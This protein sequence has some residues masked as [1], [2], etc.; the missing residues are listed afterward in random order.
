MS[1]LQGLAAIGAAC[2]AA[3]C[4]A[5]GPAWWRWTVFALYLPALA[6]PFLVVEDQRLVRAVGGLWAFGAA[7]RLYELAREPEPRPWWR[8]VL[9]TTFVFDTRYVRGG[10]PRVAG[11]LWLYALLT[12]SLA[13]AAGWVLLG[14]LLDGD[15]RPDR[16]V[17]RWAVMLVCFY[18][19]AVAID[20]AL[21]AA[22]A[23]VGVVVE[24]THDHPILSRSIGE[25]W[26]R[27]WNRE[28][29]RWLD[30]NLF[31]PLARRRRA[32]LGVLVAFGFSAALHVYPTA[33]GAGLVAAALAGAFFLAHGAAAVLERRLGVPRWSPIAGRAWTV[34]VVLLTWPLFAEPLLAVLW[35]PGAAALIGG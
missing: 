8:R 15:P 25:L 6:L 31:R 9:A 10:R 24:P 12:G 18:G 34:A 20:A 23:L 19:A 17:A 28:I 11:R 32:R 7:M 5:R 21:A 13:A 22:L 26:F 2:I 35:G 14:Y 16:L 29:G 3:A 33:A 30:F 4:L 27:R 1:P